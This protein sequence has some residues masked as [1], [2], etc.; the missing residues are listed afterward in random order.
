VFDRFRQAD[1]STRR[2]F[3]G[4][5]LGLSIAKQLVEHHGGTI[6]AQ[7]DGAGKGSTFTVDIPVR[8]LSSA[9]EETGVAPVVGDPHAEPLP[10]VRLDGLRVLIVD[11]EPIARRALLRI[12]QNAGAIALAAESAAE[13]LRL[14]MSDAPEVLVSD[15]AMPG[16]DG[17]D[18]IRQ[19][20][21]AGFSV[22]DLPAVALTAFAHKEDR[23][24][25]LLAGFQVHVAKPVDPQDLMAV[26]G[27][28][29]GRTGVA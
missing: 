3:G 24:R 11:D 2:T 20:R 28:L 25:A 15:I 13:A 16:T 8:V 14:V 29:M 22:R 12:L 18:L 26:I 9:E 23:R 7:S 19:V 6:K 27:S 1:S 4:L 10:K 21:A 17:Y 5:G